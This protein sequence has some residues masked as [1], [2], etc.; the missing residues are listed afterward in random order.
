MYKN[1]SFFK[2]L[3]E[4]R[5][6]AALLVLCHHSETIRLKNNLFNF[7]WLSLFRNGTN[8][9]NFFFVLS[10]FLITYLLLKES[11]ITND[12]KVKKF[13]LK[14]VLRI[15]PLYF[16]LFFI[17]TILLPFL[18][19]IFSIPYEM[20]YN[21]SNVW[22]YFVFF[23]PGL[24]LF[25]YG[26]HFLEPLWSIG[27]EEL[28]YL[29]WAP[30][31][32]FFKKHILSILLGVIL[33]KVLT[34]LVSYILLPENHIINHLLNTHSFELMAIGGWGAYL[35]FNSNKPIKNWLIFQKKI[36]FII[37]ILLIIF[38]IFNQNINISLWNFFFKTPILS[39]LIIGFMYL[40]SI[41]GISLNENSIL[42]PHNKYISYLGE[43]SYGIYMYHMSS[44]FFVILILK[45]TLSKL[46]PLYSSLLF[47]ILV[48]SL[49]ILISSL[50]KKYFE[51]FFLIKL[52]NKLIKNKIS[53]K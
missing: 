10:G 46:S 16:L 43:I 11:K 22:A 40:Y 14:R 52:R 17:G 51:D 50:S 45:D 21:F 9:V 23:L 19:H 38:L 33:F 44:I 42:K 41:I 48:I 24:V 15:W 25:F 20:P 26:H 32:K 53:N 34:L 18:F 30:I 29:I 3:N 36:Q 39:T 8:A 1:I 13:Y 5:F 47:Y 2:G 12:I 27:V 37:Y 35:V 31:F 7:E 49:T 28:F 4:L 6:M